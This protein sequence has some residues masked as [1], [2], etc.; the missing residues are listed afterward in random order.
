M[1]RDIKFITKKTSWVV[2]A[3]LVLLTVFAVA[4]SYG[5][6]WNYY[7]RAG[8][9]SIPA[10]SYNTP[11]IPAVP[12]ENILMWGYQICLDNTYAVCGSL[13]AGA[14]MPPQSAADIVVGPPTFPGPV[15]VASQGDTL[16]ITLRNNLTTAAATAIGFASMITEPT[17]LMIPSQNGTTFSPVWVSVDANG[18]VTGVT[19]SGFPF[20]PGSPGT[21]VTSRVRSF[22]TETPANNSTNITYTWTGLTPGTYL[23]ESATHPAVQVQM[24]LAGALK[25]FP[26]ATPA[27]VGAVPPASGQAYNK[28]STAYNFDVVLVFSEIDQ[29]LH[30]SVGSGLYG[31]PPPPPPG[32]V[33]RGQR[34]STVEY[35]PNF[36]LINGKPYMSTTVPIPNAGAANSTTLLRLV[37]AG[38]KE[39]TPT[40]INPYMFAMAEDGRLYQFMDNTGTL[41]PYTVRHTSI[42]LSAGKTIDATIVPTAS[43]DYAIFDR[44]LNMTNANMPGI[45]GMLRFLHIN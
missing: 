32:P 24:G 9:T 3:I 42:L 17:S 30:Y 38:L 40:I 13:A 22:T 14:H 29:E 11:V 28:A 15:L 43:G 44:S 26:S 36:F 18:G 25:V 35:S 45:G 21:D 7:L 27:T 19:G 5:A 33:V 37:N 8:V 20:R 23:Y 2:A 6:T 41:T 1:K 34:T 10:G 12:N 31:T 39:K 16:N 4:P